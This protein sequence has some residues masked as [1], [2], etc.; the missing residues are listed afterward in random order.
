M[1]STIKIAALPLDIVWADIERNLLTV[2]EKLTGIRPDTDILVLP[3]LFSTGFVQ[4][5]A[6]LRNLAATS[7]QMTLAAV[8]LWSSRFNMAI[9]GSYLASIG[10]KIVNRG[11]FIEPSGETTFYDKH[12]LFCLSAESRIFSKGMELPP[13]IRFRGWNFSLIVCYD[14]RFPVW[15]RN[16]NQRYDILLVPANWAS[17]RGYAW[18]QL[19]IARAIENQSV[20]VGANRS[21][22]DDY[23]DYN[24]QS[25]IFDPFG[26]EL[27]P[28]CPMNDSGHG[29]DTA[30]SPDSFIYAEYTM[31]QLSKVRSYLPVGN[32]ADSFQIVME[33]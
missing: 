9:A 27:A 29:L 32:D 19:L 30:N 18:R 5:E 28:S 31:A 25:F 17:A 7:A 2:A 4:D 22:H 8:K 6:M 21:G 16:R 15:C 3:E 26:K 33:D 1:D 24:H 11:F 23:G 14:L 10:S 20:V 12:H 13:V